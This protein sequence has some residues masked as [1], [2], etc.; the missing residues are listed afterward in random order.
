VFARRPRGTG[1]RFVPAHARFVP[2]R[3]RFVPA[4]ARFVPARAR[5]GT[6]SAETVEASVN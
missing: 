5:L 2:A 4:R 6:F 1:A 3:A